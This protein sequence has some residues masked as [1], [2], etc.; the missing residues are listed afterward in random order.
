MKSRFI[1]GLWALLFLA[2]LNAVSA[3]TPTVSQAA[4]NLPS[5][6]ETSLLNGINAMRLEAGAAALKM[7]SALNAAAQEQA[8]YLARLGYLSEKGARSLSIAAL[9]ADHGYGAGEEIQV[10]QNI[11]ISTLKTEP[12]VIIS[13]VWMK[14]G[15]DRVEMLD[16]TA[17]HIGIGISDSAARRYIVVFFGS[18]KSGAADYT[19]L[20]T[21]N[22]L[23]PSPPVSATRTRK[24]GEAAT[25][26][27]DGSIYHDIQAGETL[28][29][30]SM[31]YNVDWNTLAE[32]NKLDLADPVIYEGQK[33]LIRPKFTATLT[34]TVT[35]TPRPPTR[36]P[37]PTFTVDSAYRKPSASALPTAAILPATE[38]NL[39]AVLDQLSSWLK[40]IA[41]VL[42]ALSALGLIFL[43]VFRRHHQ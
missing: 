42:T 19:P 2:C 15:K 28:S 10:K 33:L 35:E 5:G 17:V 40:P 14:D 22:P 11:A 37:R 18:L 25:A 1:L 12:S 6:Y 21:R 38:I 4:E 30:I 7:D 36:T 20:P 13:S 23:T 39:P 16:K 34:P 31:A 3:Q 32:L 43:F 26:N 27:P 41:W 29:D 24:V 9:A 8:A